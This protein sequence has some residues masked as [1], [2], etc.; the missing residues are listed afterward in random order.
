M[1]LKKSSSSE[2]DADAFGGGDGV[3]AGEA[4]CARVAALENK[5]TT[6]IPKWQNDPLLLRIVILPDYTCSARAHLLLA[7]Y[8]HD[9]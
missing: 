1:F 7:N 3:A 2:G 4:V 5:K 6:T 9:K 8:Q